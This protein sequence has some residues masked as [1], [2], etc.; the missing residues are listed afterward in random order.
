M[1]GSFLH[2]SV[3][4]TALISGWQI[5]VLLGF[6]SGG[7]SF[8]QCPPQNRIIPGFT[9]FYTSSTILAASP[10]NSSGRKRKA[11]KSL[12]FNR[13]S[14]AFRLFSGFG[15]SSLTL[16]QKSRQHGIFT[17]LA[18]IF[19]FFRSSLPLHQL[20]FQATN[21]APANSSFFLRHRPHRHGPS[22]PS[23]S[24]GNAVILL[25]FVSLF[26]VQRP[27]PL[28]RTGAFL[29]PGRCPRAWLA[30]SFSLRVMNYKR[31]KNLRVN[32]SLLL[33]IAV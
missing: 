30:S 12:V 18:G 23:H 32:I 16:W 14:I 11:Q 7:S 15:F 8:F 2:L 33:K 24:A 21:V 27:A 4:C 1:P 26:A 10:G 28:T 22:I 29:S 31:V 19:S 25:D 6:Y 9:A 13:F 5:A 17:G 20:P 3:A